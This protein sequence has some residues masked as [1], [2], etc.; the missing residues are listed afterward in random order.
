[1]S[2][3]E[4]LVQKRIEESVRA[5]QRISQKLMRDIALA[6]DRIVESYAG[7]GKLILF[8]NGGSAADA[9]HIAGEMVGRFL[10]ERR[11]LEAI[12]LGMNVSTL[13]AI[14]ND[15]GYGRVFERELEATAKPEDVVVAISTSG[16]SPNVLRAIKRAKR[17]GC[18]TIAMTGQSGGKL[19]GEA[20]ILLNVPSKGPSPRIQELH[21]LIGHIICELVER[22]VGANKK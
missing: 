8:G 4:K 20:D 17:I 6:A 12:A 3:G 5:K 21:I 16:D 14:G 11:P 7:G 19:K 22:G 18:A 15:Y 9:Q 10:V 1:M 13:T 2:D